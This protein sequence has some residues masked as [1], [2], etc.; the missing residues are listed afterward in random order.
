MGVWSFRLSRSHGGSEFREH[1]L[2]VV[3]LVALVVLT[4]FVNRGVDWVVQSL[5]SSLGAKLDTRSAALDPQLVGAVLYAGVGLA[6]IGALY[7]VVHQR[8]PA[9]ERL[10]SHELLTLFGSLGALALG[11][12]YV[13]HGT[14]DLPVFPADL[15]RP[16]LH[17]VVVMGA[18]GL[19]YA[20]LQGVDVGLSRL[21]DRTTLIG[22]STVFLAG[23]ISLGWIVAFVL[24]EDPTFGSQF[25]AGSVRV[26]PTGF[27]AAEFPS[28]AG[29]VWQV[30][31]P[32]VF[33]S[34][35]IAILFFGAFQSGLR[36]HAGAAEAAGAVT[37]LFVVHTVGCKSVPDRSHPLRDRTGKSLQP[38]VSVV[39][40]GSHGRLR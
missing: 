33:T 5:P 22:F 13:L 26:T 40:D 37:S 7:A 24:V 34:F 30:G 27:G 2:I 28:L 32:A 3:A 6:V 12:A 38:T 20:W 23:L 9:S 19:G 10:Q 35:G 4:R 11:G 29:L 8:R 17:G 21:D 31:L 36:T 1:G 25:G 15:V 16:F 14:V 39:R 18:I